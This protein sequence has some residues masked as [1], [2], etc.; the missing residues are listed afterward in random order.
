MNAAE[1][2]ASRSLQLDKDARL[3]PTSM[4]LTYRIA[5]H[6]A[7]IAYRAAR[8]EV[9]DPDPDPNSPCAVCGGTMVCYWKLHLEV[10]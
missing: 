6:Y 3:L 9:L 1:V 7:F 5:K 8:A 4:A 2:Y 10:I